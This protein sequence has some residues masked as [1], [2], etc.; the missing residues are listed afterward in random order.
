MLRGDQGI[1]YSEDMFKLSSIHEQDLLR[2]IK[3]SIKLNTKVTI[4]KYKTK[5]L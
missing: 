4:I 2:E 5:E 1:P 3:K